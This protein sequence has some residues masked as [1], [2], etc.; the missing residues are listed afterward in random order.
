MTAH[1][2]IEA[3]EKWMA[4]RSAEAKAFSERAEEEMESLPEIPEYDPFLSEEENLHNDEESFRRL[5]QYWSKGS[6]EN[7]WNAWREKFGKQRD[8]FWLQEASSS[9][10]YD[11]EFFLGIQHFKLLWMAFYFENLGHIARNDE[12]AREVRLACRLLEI[13]LAKGY[14]KDGQT[15]PYVN[16]RNAHRFRIDDHG[17]GPRCRRAEVRFKKAYCLYFDWVKNHLLGWTD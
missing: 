1:Y 11:W 13:I 12:Q 5:Q 15:L 8:E 9:C 17:Q 6:Q 2:D 7:E 3:V 10:D 14:D 4:E 16:L